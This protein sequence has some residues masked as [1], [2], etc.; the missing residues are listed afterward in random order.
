MWVARKNGSNRFSRFDVY[1]IQTPYWKNKP[2][3]HIFLG[4]CKTKIFSRNIHYIFGLF[5]WLKRKDFPWKNIEF[6]KFKKSINVYRKILKIL[7]NI[8][9]YI[10]IDILLLCSVDRVGILLIQ[11]F[12]SSG[13][14]Y[15]FTKY[16][17]S[18]I[19]ISGFVFSYLNWM[20]FSQRREEGR[21]KRE[22]RRERREERGEER[23]ER[24]KRWEDRG[25]MR[26]FIEL[27]MRVYCCKL[28]SHV[29]FKSLSLFC[30][31]IE[32]WGIASYI[33]TSWN[34]LKAYILETKTSRLFAI[35]FVWMTSMTWTLTRFLESYKSKS[36]K[37]RMCVC[38]QFVG[39]AT[40]LKR[41]SHCLDS[42]T[43]TS[44]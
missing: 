3:G 26:D 36:F 41:D 9:I 2:K 27:T 19:C 13:Q 11:A 30:F 23:G 24:V 17:I 32:W 28:R 8:Y 12:K 5:V 40:E 21:E 38:P 44:S 25:E 4:N 31:Q 29:T 7:I 39:Q 33:V 6:F 43:W 22:E 35:S 20:E 42:T 10:C 1:R 16:S 15:Y 14:I 18:K 34:R 37:D